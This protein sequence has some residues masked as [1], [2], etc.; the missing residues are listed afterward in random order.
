MPAIIKI[1]GCSLILLQQS[2]ILIVLEMTNS[3]QLVPTSVKK[4]E[5]DY[6]KSK[7]LYKQSHYITQLLFIVLSGI[8]PILLIPERMPKV[9]PGV[10]AG[11]ASAIAAR[12]NALK[13]REKYALNKITYEKIRY[14]IAKF[15]E[16]NDEIKKNLIDPVFKSHLIRL[17]EWKEIIEEDD[18]NDS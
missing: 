16:P 5:E 13:L 3:K 15:E 17:E 8:T 2:Y 14:E 4:L 12:A 11:L 1:G 10:T 18:P 6:K 7:H 9:V